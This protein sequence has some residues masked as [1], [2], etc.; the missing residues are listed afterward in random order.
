MQ[1]LWFSRSIIK[2]YK[3]NH[4]RL[5]FRETKQPYHIWISE[6]I[7]QQTRIE[8]GLPYYNK[9]IKA[10]PNVK[11]LALA[12]EKDVLQLWQG[13][14]YYSRAINLQK[15]AQHIYK[16]EN[17]IFP[18][19]YVDW[20]K[21]N[22]VGPYT[23][24]AICSIAFNQKHAAVDGNVIRVLSRF[25]GVKEK[26]RPKL[27]KLIQEKADLL[28]HPEQAG[29]HNQ[30]LM[31]IGALVCS[32]K[33]PL[34]SECPVNSKCF[35]FQKNQTDQFPAKQQKLKKVVRYFYY[36]FLIHKQKVIVQKRSMGDIWRQLYQLP[37]VESKI[38]LN[39]KQVE[40]LSFAGYSIAPLKDK[41]ILHKKHLLSHQK[42][43]IFFLKQKIEEIKSIQGDYQLVPIKDLQKFPFPV[44]IKQAIVALLP[45][46]NGV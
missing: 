8:Q 14:G 40:E 23:A 26:N 29:L 7:F 2:W 1:K 31:E 41:M 6:I 10:F 11:K 45:P 21:L 43:E 17:G 9:F 37:L 20:L 4:R 27:Q 3:I 12:S 32:P 24:A 15:A 33:S 44:P 35:A 30:A 36:A 34:C 46:I 28:I 42:L 16:N 39:R 18:R 22:G 13:L 19:K 38:K 5:P 25:F